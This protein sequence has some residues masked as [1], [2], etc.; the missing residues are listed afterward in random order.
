MDGIWGGTTPEERI[1]TRREQSA[2][3]RRARKEWQEPG[4]RA[5]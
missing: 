3:R 5:S 2:R 1:K 4:T